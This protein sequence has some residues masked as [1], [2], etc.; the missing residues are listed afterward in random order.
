MRHYKR[1]SDPA[2]CTMKID[3][4]KAY[5]SLDWDFL[6]EM[7]EGLEFLEKFVN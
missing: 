5:G 4:R 3:L 1:K 7:L 2:R 6:R